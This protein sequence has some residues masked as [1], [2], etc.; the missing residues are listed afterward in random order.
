MG[1]D[2]ELV[3]KKILLRRRFDVTTYMIPKTS[4]MA[5]AASASNP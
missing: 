5:A 2:D 3:I 4:G 1:M